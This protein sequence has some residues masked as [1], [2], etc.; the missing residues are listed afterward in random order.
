M[1]TVYL[2]GWGEDYNDTYGYG[3]EIRFQDKGRVHYASPM[4]PSGSRIKS[5]RSKTNFQAERKAPELPLLINGQ[6]YHIQLDMTCDKEE[7]IQLLIEFYDTDERLIE[8]YFYNE[9]AG[10]FTYPQAAASYAVHLINKDHRELIFE[11]LM[12]VSKSAEDQVRLLEQGQ[13][14][15]QNGENNEALVITICQQAAQMTFGLFDPLERSDQLY[16]FVPATD[17]QMEEALAEIVA[18]VEKQG[19]Y[20]E[21]CFK[22]GRGFYQ[23]PTEQR[24][25][26]ILLELLLP[27]QQVT[28][29]DLLVTKDEQVAY[30]RIATEKLA[31]LEAEAIAAALLEAEVESV[32]VTEEVIEPSADQD[33]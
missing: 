12:I 16:F 30:Q 3:A 13:I 25:R 27:E 1:E 15:F 10:D 8:E 11:G 9:L 21:L 7:A 28:A 22:R 20:Q 18:L 4:M 2:I 6:E 31:E 24:V 32:P 26:P 5:W 19:H 23:I 17:Q 29:T 14:F 33:E